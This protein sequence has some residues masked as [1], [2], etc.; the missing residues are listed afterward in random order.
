MLL[1]FLGAA[2]ATPSPEWVALRPGDP[3]PALGPDAR[4]DRG[5]RAATEEL[6]AAATTPN[7]RLTP[8]ATRIA[9]ARAGYPGNARFL[10]GQGGAEL[11]AALLEALP[12]GQPVDV[13][14]AFRELPDKTRWWV[15]G[16]APRHLSL[17]PLPRD[18]ALGQ[19][20]A[21]RV[22]G[23]TRPRLLV[24]EPAGKVRELGLHDGVARWVAGL[25]AP[26]EYRVEVVDEDRV[27]LLFSLFVGSH[28]PNA[29][30]LPGPAPVPDLAADLSVLYGA[31]DRFRADAGLP[32]LA[33][34]ADFEPHARAHAACLAA[35]GVVAHDTPSCPGVPE[36]AKRT[37]FPRARHIE[38]V[39]AG[40]TTEEAWERVLASPGHVQN[41][42]CT[43]CTAV[44]IG[45]VVDSGRAYIVWEMLELPEG[46]PRPIRANGP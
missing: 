43:A 12:R 30:P 13:G 3:L 40:D 44:S 31:L 26:G 32:P 19:G 21:I 17:D 41:L 18:L 42:L 29:R 9:L 24:V 11:P 22:D 37:H 34:F 28:P 39:A 6:A 25:D 15:V 1:C 7:A 4:V 14:W 46:L 10:V 8:S 33:R 2:L 16:W 38:D 20:V 5:L 45:G 27:E 35:A 23:A 36:L